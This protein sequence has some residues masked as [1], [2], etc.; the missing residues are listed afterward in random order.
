MHKQTAISRS[1]NGYFRKKV[2]TTVSGSPFPP[3]PMPKPAKSVLFLL[4]KVQQRLLDP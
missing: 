4:Q 3:T 1:F 2:L